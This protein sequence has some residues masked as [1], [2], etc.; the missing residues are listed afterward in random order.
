MEFRISGGELEEIFRHMN[1]VQNFENLSK[2]I[3]KDSRVLV[4][5][6]LNAGISRIKIDKYSRKGCG[7]I[8]KFRKR[9]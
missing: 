8:I 3:M 1:N 2:I 5:F 6:R 7:Y 9:K 4:L